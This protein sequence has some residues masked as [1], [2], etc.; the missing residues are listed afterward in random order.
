MDS[1]LYKSNLKLIEAQELEREAV[2]NNSVY[3]AMK[4]KSRIY[5]LM[6]KIQTDTQLESQQLSNDEKINKSWDIVF[7]DTDIETI[8]FAPNSINLF[9][10]NTS[11]VTANYFATLY[12]KRIKPTYADEA[13]MLLQPII[14]FSTFLL[15]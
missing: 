11:Y 3:S 9:A 14:T 13:I 8:N 4:Y 6:Y 15:I 10:A 7:N 12:N 5:L 1:V 2:I